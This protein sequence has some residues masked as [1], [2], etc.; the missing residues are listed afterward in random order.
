[1]FSTLVHK[2]S[3][4]SSQALPTM[5]Y[6]KHLPMKFGR[7]KIDTTK[8][9]ENLSWTI[10]L[11]KKL[12]KFGGLCLFLSPLKLEKNLQIKNQKQKL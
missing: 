4:K 1:M 12:K 7:H 5:K 11:P 10:W 3:A 9:Q 2:I 8:S 6:E